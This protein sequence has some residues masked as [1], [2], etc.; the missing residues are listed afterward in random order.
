MIFWALVCFSDHP[1]E[2]A[3]TQLG[4]DAVELAANSLVICVTPMIKRESFVAGR[5][6]VV[7]AP[8]VDHS[9]GAHLLVVVVPG[10]L[11]Q[12]H[13]VL[14]LEELGL[15]VLLVGRF[16]WT[17]WGDVPRLIAD[18]ACTSFGLSVVT[19]RCCWFII[20]RSWFGI[21]R[22]LRWSLS[23]IRMPSVLFV[24]GIR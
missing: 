2:R 7:V 10:F 9:C 1:K 17:I 5:A 12:N 18:V 4:F 14:V 6:E 21:A 3:L 24:F 8:R 13:E 23:Q 16:V 22:L 15:R 20:R 11:P 19:S